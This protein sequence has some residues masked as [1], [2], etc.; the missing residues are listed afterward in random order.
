MGNNHMK[1]SEFAEVTGIT[2]RNLLFY[3]KIGL[4]SPAKID[5]Y[6]KYR[7]YTDYQVDTASIINI[8]REIGMPLK[9]IKEYLNGRSPENFI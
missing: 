4:L 2:R 6:N 3:D 1:I 7:Y 5:E 9:E 8:L